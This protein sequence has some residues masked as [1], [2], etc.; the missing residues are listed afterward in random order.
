MKRINTLVEDIQLLVTTKGW[1]NAELAREFSDNLTSRLSARSLSVENRPTLRLSQMGPRCPRALW[2]SIHH[3]ELAES[4]PPW[5]EI[6]Y[7]FGDI[8]EAY[9]IILAKASG[10][11]VE[12]EQD[13]L[14]LDG[15]VGHRDCVID[16]CLVDVKSTSSRGFQKFK[17]PRYELVD[18]FGYLDQLDGYVVA[19]ADDP[20]V[21]VKDKGYILAIDKT[22]G[23][24]VLY[25]HT[26][27]EAHIKERIAYYKRIVAYPTPPNC[28]CRTVTIGASGNI[29]L[30]IKAGYNAYKHCCFPNLRTF[31]YANGPV[32]LTKV[33]RKP[34]VPEITRYGALVH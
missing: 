31:L 12:G 13:E 29:G 32:F 3:S 8:I 17:S 33:V 26:V 7:T 16:G 19:S 21:Q 23:H 30:D 27:R 20:I 28:E 11:T 6:K 22:L 24:M 1:F 18:S 10:H 25:E 5:A 9:A 2:Y 14:R 4:L 34:D 15:I